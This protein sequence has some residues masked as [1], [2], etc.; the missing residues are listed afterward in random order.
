[1]DVLVATCIFEGNTA[2]PNMLSAQSP[3]LLERFGLARVVLVT[4]P[5]I[6]T[7]IQIL[8]I[9]DPPGLDSIMSPDHPG[10]RLII[11]R[12]PVLADRR[13]WKG[14]ELLAATKKDLKKVVEAVQRPKNLLQGKHFDL[15]FEETTSSHGNE[16]RRR[17]GKKP[18]STVST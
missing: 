2:D 16:T 9:R 12:N 6:L 4:D 1:M 17:P 15:P 8:K 10:E 11:C 7:Q 18:D 5:G 14:G 13:T 3:K